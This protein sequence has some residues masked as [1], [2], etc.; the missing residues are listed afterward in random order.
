[1]FRRSATLE[2]FFLTYSH[3]SGHWT[4]MIVVI[5]L[6]ASWLSA[7]FLQFSWYFTRDFLV[8]FCSWVAN[9]REYKETTTATATATS[10]NKRHREQ[11]NYSRN[12]NKNVLPLKI[13]FLYLFAQKVIQ[14]RYNSWYI[15]L[16]SSAKQQPQMT[17]FCV[18]R[19]TWPTTN[20][21]SNLYLES[22]SVCSILSFQIDLTKRN[23]LN[24]FRVSQ[25]LQVKYN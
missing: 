19:T 11:R 17:K 21:F 10:L 6:K 12:I 2:C 3:I 4:L 22:C 24:E 20:N 23:K 15:F 1:M 8:L 25:D 7:V 5:E 9:I 18:V 16:R 13:A 14:W